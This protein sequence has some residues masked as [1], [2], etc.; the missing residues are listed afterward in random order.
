M[1][2]VECEVPHK[3]ETK[4]NAAGL[5]GSGVQINCIVN[6]REILIEAPIRKKGILP[7]LPIKHPNSN[8]LIAAAAP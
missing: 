7:I 4:K 5:D 1:L 6:N 2:T 8:A 3:K